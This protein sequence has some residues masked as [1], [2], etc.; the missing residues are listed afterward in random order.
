[1]RRILLASLLFIVA[2][3]LSAQTHGS[4][5]STA[6]TTVQTGPIPD[7]SARPLLIS[8]KVMVDDGSVV[9][10]P[11]A[12]QSTCKGRTHVEAYTDSKGRFS[13]EI[14]SLEQ[15]SATADQ[16]SDSSQTTMGRASTETSRGG[17]DS[18]R[19]RDYWRDCSLQ[20]VLPGFTSTPVDLAQ[21]LTSFGTSDVG[22]MV[23]HRS[24]QVQGLTISVTSA[25]ASP[26]AKKEYDKGRELEK[27]EKWDAA[28][29]SFQK[30]VEEYPNYAIAWFE[31]GRV[32]MQKNEIVAARESFHR[33]TGADPKFVSPYHEL[34]WL[35]ERD[36]QW[37][38]MVD[39]SDKVL[40]LNPVD[41]PQDWL[42]NAVGNFQLQNVDAAEKSSRRGLEIDTRHQAPRL[43]YVLALV[44]AQKHDYTQA[45]EHIK[46]YLRLAPN[47]ADAETAKQQAQAIE[48]LA[49]DRAS[50]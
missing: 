7:I 14:K 46:N 30:A 13:F 49:A 34:A 29:A 48:R 28:L 11:V 44:L 45:L 20:P 16:A 47:A 27:K 36:Q 33:A 2:L 21:K 50:Q 42:S 41:F 25:Q 3:E 31:M 40:K 38:E 37:Q 15:N 9:T 17:P 19:L 26:K 4:R 18:D 12:V 32:Q 8:G 23:M 24:A 6:H 5:P 22:T 1:M 35:A 10:D 43:E 39:E